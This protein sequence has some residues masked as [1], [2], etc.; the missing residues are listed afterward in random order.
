MT[1]ECIQQFTLRITQ[2][3]RTEI[4]VI[5]YE[6]TL[7]YLKEGREA[8]G[9]GDKTAF[10]EAIRKARG[11]F[12]ELIQSLNMEY[13]IAGN[14]LQLYLYCL[15]RVTYGEVRKDME[16]LLQAEK[17]ISELHRAYVQLSAQDKS[18]P[19]MHNSQKVYAGLTYG[20]NT[21]TENMADQG[22]DR[23]IRV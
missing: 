10:R 5:L 22:S 9:A 19:V 21:L 20:K 11:C 3:N 18:G 4:I 23:G 6:M 12:N 17:V 1:R 7:C 8:Y 14:L 16:A 2:A 15:R 13:D